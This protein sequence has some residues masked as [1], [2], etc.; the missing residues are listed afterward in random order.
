MLFYIRYCISQSLPTL[1]AAFGVFM[2]NS[3]SSATIS[4]LS[5]FAMSASAFAAEPPPSAPLAGSPGI[6]VDHTA[7]AEQLARSMAAS[8]DPAVAAIAT[9]DQYLI[10]EVHRGKIA[11]PAIHPGW[12]EL[13][14]VLE[15]SATFV[16]G[17]KI[18]AGKD[19]ASTIDGGVGRKISKGDV[20][21]VPPNTP[22]WYQRIDAGITVV[23]VRFIAP[24]SAAAAK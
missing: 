11:P 12:T 19:G 6:Y 5:A 18:V 15:G 9:T 2:R 21:I 23:E 22:H 7:V 17:G 13:H 20:V 4:L 8:N 24:V 14:M 10:N 1:N 3:K 16:T